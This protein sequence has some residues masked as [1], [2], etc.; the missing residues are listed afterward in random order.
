MNKANFSK[1]KQTEMYCFRPLL[2]RRAVA[3][4]ANTVVRKTIE[5]CQFLS[6]FFAHPVVG[7][8][9]TTTMMMTMPIH[10][11]TFYY[12]QTLS[13]KTLFVLNLCI[14]R[15]LCIAIFLLPFRFR[16]FSSTGRSIAFSNFGFFC[17]ALFLNEQ[18][19]L[20]DVTMLPW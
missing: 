6:L 7:L 1:K 16:L 2:G 14:H 15:G 5:D 19:C 3:A 18:L 13:K 8:T 20:Y 9:T 11:T 12:R 10:S 17:L 4:A